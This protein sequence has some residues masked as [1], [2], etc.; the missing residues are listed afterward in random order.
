MRDWRYYVARS[1][2]NT[3]YVLLGAACLGMLGLF[4]YM[5]I[6]VPEVQI[7]LLFVAVGAVVTL[8]IS[9]TKWAYR[10]IEES[11]RP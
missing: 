8:V 6:V 4:I 3:V 2:M 11:R 1:W 7:F 10:Y 9:F 5:A